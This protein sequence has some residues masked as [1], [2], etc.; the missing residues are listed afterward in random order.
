MRRTP[1][2]TPRPVLCLHG[3]AAVD[4]PS[5][6]TA[7]ELSM[8]GDGDDDL[9]KLEATVAQRGGGFTSAEKEMLR[10][11]AEL[12]T[13]INSRATA[14]LEAACLLIVIFRIENIAI[15]LQACAER[16]G[17]LSRVHGKK[18]VEAIASDGHQSAWVFRAL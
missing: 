9:H 7:S 8:R 14:S 6:A 1:I 11:M 5:L 12:L 17:F 16:I 3:A 13:I 10:V 15:V 2:L 18:R 4:A